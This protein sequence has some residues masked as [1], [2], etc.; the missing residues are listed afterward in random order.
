MNPRHS[1]SSIINKRNTF[2][3]AL[4]R[5]DI[6]ALGFGTM[7]GWSWVMVTTTWINEAGFWGAI[8]AF[9]AGA[10][11]I[12]LVGLSYGEL[13]SALP[14]AGGEIV[15][16]YRAMGKQV[17]WLVGWIMAFAYIAVAA[18]E[19]IAIST[20]LDYLLPIPSFIHLWDVSGAPVYLSWA[21][22]GMVG[23]IAMTLLNLFATR[24]AIIFQVMATA[25][26]IFIGFILLFGGVTFGS[27]DNLEA[28][29]RSGNGLTYVFL[30]VPSMLVGFDVIPQSAEEMNIPLRDVGRMVVVCIILACLWYVMIIIGLTLAAPFEV[31][32][33]GLIPAADVMSYAY[34]D[35]LFGK[36][37]IMGGLLGILTCWNGF[38]MG[39][40]RLLFA[41][42]RA[43][44]LPAVFGKLHKTHQTP[45]AATLVVGIICTL[46][47]L[48]GKNA[49]VWLVN[50][51]AFCTLFGYFIV[52]GSFVVLRWKE[53]DLSRPFKLK[54][55]KLIGWGALIL[56]GLYFFLFV[57]TTVVKSWSEELLFILLWIFIG[58]ILLFIT[59]LQVGKVSEIE[60][61]GLI[62][63]EEFSRKSILYNKNPGKE[64]K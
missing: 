30:M 6:L 1:E 17:A 54:G 7:V 35:P 19:S 20:A 55:G 23:A 34:G 56:S 64:V 43:K 9:L 45:W 3:K 10:S 61:E 46:S 63:G 59:H 49:F 26:F 32:S 24:P 13:T 41:M 16:V 18:W 27:T 50:A 51:S 11:I 37:V 21:L 36:I 33:S 58:L 5:T 15:Y 62:F 2:S 52:S 57:S 28:L 29:F 4:G 42:G 38:F 53:P 47:P 48:L 14:L 12:I 40:S 44:M 8:I 25:G 60:R 31:R 22:V 39:A